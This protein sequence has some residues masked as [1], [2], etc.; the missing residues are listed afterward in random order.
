[1]KNMVKIIATL[2]F[3]VTLLASC[4]SFGGIP[5][6][7]PPTDLEPNEIIQLAQNAYEKGNNKASKYYYN[8][9]LKRFGE[10]P[11]YYVIGRFE[12]A[13][14]AIKNKEYE[15][16]VPMLEEVIEIYELVPPE[17]LPPSYKKLAEI[18][19][20]KVPEQTREAVKNRQIQDNENAPSWLQL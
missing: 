18:D 20:E 14:I 10:Y 13:H 11:S 12:I 1:M 17:Y 8:I 6:E 7:E 15:T 4:S 2:L 5:K 3:S 16:A 9:L 19:L